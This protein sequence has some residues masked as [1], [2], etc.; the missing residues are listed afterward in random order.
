MSIGMSEP[1]E[2]YAHQITTTPT[3]PDFQ[4]YGPSLHIKRCTN[5]SLVARVNFSN[6]QNLMYHKP[7]PSK[8]QPR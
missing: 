6:C 5:Q 2:D 7:C 4:T 8:K 1:G 3:P